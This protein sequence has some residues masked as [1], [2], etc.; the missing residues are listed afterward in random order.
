MVRGAP[1]WQRRL[2]ARGLD[3]LILRTLSRSRDLATAWTSCPRID[4][5]IEVA[6]LAPVEPAVLS[7][8]LDWVDA[9]LQA[10]DVAH[11]DWDRES[12]ADPAV[13]AALGPSLLRCVDQ[14]PEVQEKLQLVQK[15]ERWR[16]RP[17]L[18]RCSDAYDDAHAAAHRT[19]TT[20]FQRGVPIT[21]L[22]VVLEERQAH[23]YR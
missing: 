16:D 5:A 10:W 18:M 7:D 22:R 12:I 11:L 21:A 6:V 4:W 15:A 19:L 9:A 8:G 13:L 1:T 23:P 20:A 17:K 14:A 3:P 2:A